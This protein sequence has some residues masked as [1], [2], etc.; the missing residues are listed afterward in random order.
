M[1]NSEAREDRYSTMIQ[2]LREGFIVAIAFP[3]TVGI[4]LSL[5]SGV[6]QSQTPGNKIGVN[7]EY[8]FPTKDTPPGIE[9][10]SASLVENANQWNGRMVTFRGEAIGECMVRGKMAWI[11]LND[12]AYMEKNIEEGAALGGYNSGH[13]VWVSVEMARVIRFFGDFKHDGDIA[14]VSGVFNAACREHGGDMDIHASSMEILRIGHPV[15]HL[16]NTTRMMVAAILFV[17]AGILYGIRRIA[18]RRRI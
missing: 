16:V 6:A 9:V 12:D 5:L 17:L 1:G 10:N 18:E 15:G 11:H 4:L 2:I 13:A 8:G 7:P 14:K 3:L